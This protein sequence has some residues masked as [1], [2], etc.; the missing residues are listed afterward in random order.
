[1]RTDEKNNKHLIADDGKIL[2]RKSDG[3]VA[4]K[5][6]WLG[7][8]YYLNGELLPTPFEE[9]PEH[10]EEVDAP[11]EVVEVRPEEYE[12]PE[13][14]VVLL[15]EEHPMVVEAER[16]TEDGRPEGAATSAPK[17]ITVGDVAKMQEEIERLKEVI[18]QL[19]TVSTE[20]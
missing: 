15:D 14:D 2:V 10:Y 11:E 4:G 3:F 5:E 20:D 1:M 8:T 7:M 18:K 16:V 17:V 12:T 9:L 13:G 19:T 6:F